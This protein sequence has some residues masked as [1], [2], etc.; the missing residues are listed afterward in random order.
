MSTILKASI[1]AGQ[2]A[3]AETFDELPDAEF[4]AIRLAHHGTDRVIPMLWVGGV[5]TKSVAEVMAADSTT[6]NVR[7]VS[8]V[9]QDSLFRMQWT[10][11]VGFLTHALIEE[12][13][14]VVSAHGTRDA[15]TFRIFFPRRDDV[16]A[17]YEACDTYD[18]TVEQIY[19]LDSAPS[20][21]EFRLTDGQVTTLRAAF[22]EGY[23]TVPRE[24]T[25]EELAEE[26]DVSHQALS[27]RLR[28]SHRAL[29]ERML[30]A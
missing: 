5:E 18:I 30:V 28:R 6:S 25:L 8:Q 13:G 10:D 20:F 14:A 24:T 1:P 27:E 22:D 23:Y 17:T 2:F 19:S 7:L 29:I 26:L 21:G 9:N 12:N 11:R 3:L 16:S 4:D 15:W